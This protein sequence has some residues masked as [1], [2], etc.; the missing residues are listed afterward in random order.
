MQEQTS[1]W[2]LV[3]REYELKTFAAAWAK[4]DCQGVVIYGPA[5]V[6]KSR[7]AEECLSQVTSSE[8][9]AARVTA[10][11][12]AGA[13]PLAAIAHLIPAEVDFSD[14]VKGFAAVARALAGPQRNRRWAILVDDL[15]LLDATSAVL[16]RNLLDAGAIRLIGTVRSGES[17]S[18]AVAV[19]TSGHTVQRIELADF[20]ETQ[21][22]EVLHAALKASMGRRTLERLYTTS[23]GNALY[24]RELV[25]G[26][27][28][29][30]TLVNDGEIWEL[31]KEASLTTPK[32]Y[33][34]I[35]GRLASADSETRSVL[36][37]LALCEPVPLADAQAT[38]GPEL[39]A[40]LEDA[41]LLQVAVNGQRTTLSL[42][43]PLY[44]EVLRSKIPTLRRRHL[45]LAQIDR[46]QARGAR[47]REDLLYLVAWQLAA[48][49]TAEPALLIQAATLSRHAH[50]YKQVVAFL[51]ALPDSSRTFISCVMH[52][53][54]LTQLGRQWQSADALLAEAEARA[55]RQ[56]QRVTATL[57]R[58]WNL[59]W[60]GANTDEALRVN[61]LALKEVTDATAR[62]LLILNEASMRMVSGQPTQSL[63]LLENLEINAYDAPNPGI[64]SVAA[65]CRTSGL[66]FAGRTAEAIA[67][68]EH[69]Y[70]SHLK[71]KE[72]EAVPH[73]ATQLT[74]AIV[75]L[76]DAGKLA[77]ARKMAER[78]FV[79]VDAVLTW[80]L[81][82]FFRARVE[83]LAGDAAA[84]R[85]SYA[86]T[87]AQA[88]VHRCQR[89]LF[90]AWAGL[91]AAAAVLGDVEA[92]EKALAET[93]AYPPMGYHT[94]EKD[95]GQAWLYAS[96]GQLTEARVVLSAAATK[97]RDTG[98]VT[99]EMMLLT[100]IARLGGA[101]EV[102]D[103]MTDLAESCDG[104]FA[105]ARLHLV[106]A[107]AA[108][109]PEQLEDAA[110]ELANV[111][112]F[113]L[114]AEATTTAA[115]AW[116]Q[117]G[118]TRRATAATNRTQAY[119]VHCPGVR[120]PLLA[121]AWAPSVLTAREREIALLAANGNPSKDIADILHLS[122]RTVD[123]HLQKIYSKLGITSR[124]ELTKMLGS[125]HFVTH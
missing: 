83:W 66:A 31:T 125:H 27:L 46:T 91:A 15:H 109:E 72:Q 45:L 33:E 40:D 41:G 13:V 86:D 90:H 118:Q 4:R 54:A 62:H 119:M 30:K 120:T 8:F 39:L 85:R 68:A 43:H 117:A 101:K 1:R 26:A 111:G 78:V 69:S 37:L 113:L 95:L 29:A 116:R 73:P 60:M 93:Q 28:T 89:S 42:T 64:W 82:A 88:R 56:D 16:L 55:S 80:T 121:A 52:G 65:S 48:T 102:V 122:V 75:A 92:A 97:A 115:S 25:L 20:T 87:V 22:E 21:V 23:G 5:G 108:N 70:A 38:C 9:Q 100:D 81:A 18:D 7:F 47:R 106:A 61:D 71:I 14:P 79:D 123:N 94:G 35:S 98:H 114:A 77:E 53:E 50:D 74:P 44:G 124:R 107:L 6:G 51:E 10:S 67:W 59:F 24:L 36:E 57:S 19:L 99:S 34:L 96:R 17:F 104:I 76:A 112:A 58:T 11:A 63:A 49:G 12:A 2:P 3:A 110:D 84:A 105:P 103:R 32:L